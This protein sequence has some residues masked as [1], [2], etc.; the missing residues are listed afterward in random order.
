MMFEI[1][2]ISEMKEAG[3]NG[4]EAVSAVEV[5][6]SQVKAQS[7]WDNVKAAYRFN[8]KTGEISREVYELFLMFIL[9]SAAG[10]LYGGMPASRFARNRYIQTSNAAIYS[11]KMEALGTSY[12]AGTRGFIRYGLRWGWRTGFLAIG[13]HGLSSFLAVYRDKTDLL[14]YTAA[15][16]CT[17]ALYR[18]NLGVRG[19]VGGGVVGAMLGVPAGC[20]LLAMQKLYG[21]T[22]LEVNKKKRLEDL[23]EKKK[24]MLEREHAFKTLIGNLNASVSSTKSENGPVR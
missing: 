5:A 1:Q 10:G 18:V 19:V 17:G 9:G 12:N 15:S 22:M 14:N 13:F 23:Q 20:C 21:Q 16:V 7:G 3:N 2:I 24:D 8:R 4:E 6:S 11:S